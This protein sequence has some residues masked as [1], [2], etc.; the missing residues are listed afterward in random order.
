[1]F[2]IF[3]FKGFRDIVN[4]LVEEYKYKIKIPPCEQKEKEDAINAPENIQEPRRR[5][6]PSK[7]QQ[8]IN[9]AN[10]EAASHR[11]ESEPEDIEPEEEIEQQNQLQNQEQSKSINKKKGRPRKINYTE[12]EYNRLDNLYHNGNFMIVPSNKIFTPKQANQSRII[13]KVRYKI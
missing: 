3:I 8:N 12:E 4:L 7:N 10:T 1:M 13:S 2:S 6:R 11:A 9:A 5:G